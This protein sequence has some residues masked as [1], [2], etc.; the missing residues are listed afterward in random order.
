MNNEYDKDDEILVRALHASVDSIKTVSEVLKAVQNDVAQ[1][2]IEPRRIDS[3]R[4]L[5]NLSAYDLD[6]VVAELEREK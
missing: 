1:K 2:G 4:N 5:L 3:I 6:Y